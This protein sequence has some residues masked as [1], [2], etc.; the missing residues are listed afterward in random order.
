MIRIRLSLLAIAALCA[1]G[2]PAALAESARSLHD[3]ESIVLELR[4]Y[5]L[6]IEELEEADRALKVAAAV[7]PENADWRLGLAMLDCRMR[8]FHSAIEHAK[9][10]AKLDEQSAEPHYWE[11][12]A[13]MGAL[14]AAPDGDRKKHAESG[15]DALKRAIK[16]DPQH[17]DARTLLGIFYVEAPSIIGGSAKRAEK[18]A[19]KLDEI[20][21]GEFGAK[22][23]RAMIAADDGHWGD[24][25]RLCNEAV[26]AAP[27]HTHV[28]NLR[29]RQARAMMKGD[30]NPDF[31]VAVLEPIAHDER[32]DFF[33]A[34]ALLGR[35]LLHQGDFQRAAFVLEE[36]LSANPDLAEARLDLAEC[37]LATGDLVAARD[38]YV[39]YLE[40]RPDHP[41]T[42]A[43]K[44]ALKKVRRSIARVDSDA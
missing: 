38:C 20:P 23:I 22:A 19:T 2:S 17:I 4:S 33:V 25:M 3:A 13:H 42:K 26:S 11:G 35:A 41:K 30:A 9:T 36:A 24:V 8:A 21:G 7:E 15:R 34:R 44:K 32:D 31:A 16:I 39:A 29:V 10:A 18:Q 28:F 12:A 27:T 37:H 1:W 14:A 5:A 43:A 6:A 40:K